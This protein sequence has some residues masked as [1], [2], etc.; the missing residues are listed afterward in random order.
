[1]LSRGLVADYLI[2]DWG[3]LAHGCHGHHLLGLASQAQT[4][5]EGV[6]GG[7]VAAT[8]ALKFVPDA[9]TISGINHHSG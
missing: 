8:D 1:M 5:V 2:Q 6:D 9:G 3:Q 7:V 4:C